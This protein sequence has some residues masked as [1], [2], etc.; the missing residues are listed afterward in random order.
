LDGLVESYK[1]NLFDRLWPLVLIGLAVYLIVRKQ[2][3]SQ[4]VTG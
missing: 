2:S 1:P 3:A 4:G